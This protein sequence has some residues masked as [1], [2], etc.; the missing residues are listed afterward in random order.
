ML[1]LLT[2]F[3]KVFHMRIFSWKPFNKTFN[4]VN[5]VNILRWF[6][7]IKTG[8]SGVNFVNSC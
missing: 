5:I 6:S 1:T 7:G 4:K 2:I 8:V 3:T